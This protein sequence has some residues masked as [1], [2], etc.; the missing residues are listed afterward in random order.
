MPRTPEFTVPDL[1]GTRAGPSGP[2]HVGGGPGEQKVYSR[3]RGAED[4]RRVWDVSAEMAGVSFA[5]A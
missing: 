3:L 2:G 1:T 5:A 4:A